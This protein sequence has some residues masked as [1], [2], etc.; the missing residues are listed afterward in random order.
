M[1]THFT[2]AAAQVVV[3]WHITEACNFRCRYCYAHWQ[4]STRRDLI[5][6]PAACRALLQRLFEHFAARSPQRR[7]RLNFAGGE[8]L[9]LSEDLLRAARDARQIGFDISLITNGSRLTAPLVENLAPIMSVLGVSLDSACPQTLAAIG[10]RDARGRQTLPASL[11][12]PLMRA[13][14]GN[15]ALALK[16]NTVVCGANWQE[17]LSDVIQELSPSRW[18]VL[19]MLPV[20]DRD[21]DVTD[22]QFQ[23]FVARHRRFAAISIAENNADMQGSYIM[24]DP[25]GR[26]FQNRVD[27]CGYDYSAPILQ[28]GVANAFAH[29][30]WSALKFDRRYR[31]LAEGAMK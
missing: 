9:L 29:L 25:M 8:P 3:N 11:V 30:G 5:R 19:R 10:R 7:P 6:D 28:V 26:F 16:I 23:A 31:A 13:R 21:L 2:C 18:K 12:A 14:Q 17:D 24:V 1:S 4:R 20:I 22:A 27:A 15:P